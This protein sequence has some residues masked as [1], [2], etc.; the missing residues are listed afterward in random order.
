MFDFLGYIGNSETEFN[1]NSIEHTICFV[2][3][4]TVRGEMWGLGVHNMH[5]YIRIDPLLTHNAWAVEMPS[6]AEWRRVTPTTSNAKESMVANQ[7][8]ASR[9]HQNWID[10]FCRV[11]SVTQRSVHSGNG[12]WMAHPLGGQ[13][14][15]ML[16]GDSGHSDATKNKWQR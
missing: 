11:S 15:W 2:G 3:K 7:L 4:Q 6:D 8:F 9:F 5:F 13:L 16:L 12:A 10:K 1:I 14:R